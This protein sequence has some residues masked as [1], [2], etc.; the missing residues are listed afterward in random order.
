MPGP[1]QGHAPA[2]TVDRGSPTCR[3]RIGHVAIGRCHH[4][5]SARG[6]LRSRWAVLAPFQG[7]AEFR[8]NRIKLSPVPGTGAKDANVPMFSPLTAN[9]ASLARLCVHSA[10]LKI[11][12]KHRLGA[13]P[14]PEEGTPIDCPVREEEDAIAR[15]VLQVPCRHAVDLLFPGFE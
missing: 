8:Q 4:T 6:R 13:P 11:L 9:R 7:A 15:S 14:L 2:P 3:A 12:S 1:A 10:V 5:G